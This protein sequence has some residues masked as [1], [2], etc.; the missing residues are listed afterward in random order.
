MGRAG[1]QRADWVSDTSD[2]VLT[3]ADL[4]PPLA[5]VPFIHPREDVVKEATR[6]AS[7]SLS[8]AGAAA[9]STAVSHLLL[10]VINL[11]GNIPA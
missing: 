10:Q 9:A 4:T 8:L 2:K 5:L 7:F 6:M 3:L 11:S 1:R